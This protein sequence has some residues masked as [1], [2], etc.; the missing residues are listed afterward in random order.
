MIYHSISLLGAR[1]KNEDEIDI[2]NNNDINY[3]G[4]YDGHG[5]I[6]IS[7][8]LKENL[9]KIQELCENKKIIFKNS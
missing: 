9:S 8:Y 1:E 6:D 7:R 2:I 5:G 4:I 3:Y